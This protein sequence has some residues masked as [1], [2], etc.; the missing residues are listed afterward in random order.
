MEKEIKNYIPNVEMLRKLEEVFSSDFH[1]TT[2]SSEEDFDTYLCALAYGTAGKELFYDHQITE[3]IPEKLK[4]DEMFMQG[5]LTYSL[6]KKINRA[7]EILNSSE[8]QAT[9]KIK[10]TFEE[11]RDYATVAFILHYLNTKG[12]KVEWEK[13]SHDFTPLNLERGPVS[14]V[15]SKT[16]DPKELIENVK[17]EINL[18]QNV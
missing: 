2:F 1:T 18:A 4:K 5:M 6:I 12:Y 10:F 16:V 3:Q 13:M 14:F 7:K 9:R 15:K 11:E 8:F 17:S